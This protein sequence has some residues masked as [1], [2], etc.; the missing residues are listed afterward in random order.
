[1]KVKN[2]I[3]IIVLI[4]LAFF[5]IANADVGIHLEIQTSEESLFNQS[6]LVSPCDSDNDPETPDDIT[7]YCAV[8]QSGLEN[9]W[10]WW[11]SDAFLSSIGTNINNDNDNGIYW[12][13][14]NNLDLGSIALNKYILN[15]EDRILL[16]Y[17]INPLK[18]DF[19]MSPG[20]IPFQGIKAMKELYLDPRKK[21]RHH[22]AGHK[23]HIRLKRHDPVYGFQ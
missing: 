3:S 1:M 14:F 15:E 2:K 7:A 10:S 8:L 23:N 6:V 12:G 19:K 20:S 5:T 11:G 21:V 4:W 16:T 13:W 9:D 18:N 22:I 17:N